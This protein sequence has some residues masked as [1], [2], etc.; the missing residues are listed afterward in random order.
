MQ[1]EI[2]IPS[3]IKDHFSCQYMCAKL[4]YLRPSG[5]GGVL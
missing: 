2:N 4:P 5:I 3:K 1:F